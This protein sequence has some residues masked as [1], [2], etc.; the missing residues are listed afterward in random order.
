MALR[1]Y[2]P[3]D[4]DNT[5]LRK[6]LENQTQFSTSAIVLAKLG[7]AATPRRVAVI[8]DDENTLLRK[9]LENQSGSLV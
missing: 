7:T 4:Y 5:I 8:G 6:L 9:L 2:Q 3:G 1:F